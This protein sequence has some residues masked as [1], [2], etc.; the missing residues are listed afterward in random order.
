MPEKKIALFDVEEGY[1][2][3]YKLIQA[4][5]IELFECMSAED[6]EKGLVSVSKRPDEFYR[7]VFDTATH[8]AAVT[9]NEIMLPMA[10]RLGNIW[11]SRNGLKGGYD[12]YGQTAT[13]VNMC[14]GTA[15]EM[16]RRSMQVIVTAHEAVRE[17]PGE[18]IEMHGPDLQKKILTFTYGYSDVVARLGKVTQPMKQDGKTYPADQKNPLRVLRVQD[19]A[20]YMAKGRDDVEQETKTPELI[21]LPGRAGMTEVL[22][23]FE[24]KPRKFMIYGPPGV[25][26]TVLA[27]S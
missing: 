7:I 10:N 20:K 14:F 16:N 24:V 5:K 15:Y 6:V 4:G 8:F 9:L 23:E 17:S 18:E 21:P 13:T 19:S 11:K 3:V 2:P 27:C 25:G 26:K 22:A 1:R 12:D